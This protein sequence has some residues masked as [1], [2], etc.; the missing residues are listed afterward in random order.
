[1]TKSLMVAGALAMGVLGAMQAQAA[2]ADR[3]VLK[4]GV[5]AVDPK[6]NNGDLLGNT[7]HVDVGS[8]VRPTVTLEY[9]ATPNWG[10]ETLASWPFQHHIDVNGVEVASTRQ[11]PPTVSLQYHFNPTG[12]VSPFVGIG[13]NYT[14][15]FSVHTT[16]PLAGTSLDLSSTF[17]AAAH[18]GLDFRVD[19][20]WLVSVDARYMNIAPEARLNGVRLGTVHIDPFVYG[21]AVGY[22]F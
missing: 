10:L 9:M 19:E 8:N 11:L 6:S 5:H 21:V 15:F 3:W 18:A 16:G 7:L 20:R 22:R 17:G 1:M 2:D 12:K 13:L 4:V 14:K